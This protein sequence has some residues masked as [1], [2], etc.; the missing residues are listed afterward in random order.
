MALQRYTSNSRL[1]AALYIGLY[2]HIG[3]P[4]P[5]VEIILKV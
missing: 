4:K 2:I 1:R 3:L 5:S